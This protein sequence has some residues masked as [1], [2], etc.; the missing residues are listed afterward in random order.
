MRFAIDDLATGYSSPTRIT[1]LPVDILKIDLGFVAGMGIG[2]A[3]AAVVHGNLVMGGTLGPAV[4]A[5]GVETP[6]QVRQLQGFGCQFAQ[7]YHS[8]GPLPKYEL[9]SLLTPRTTT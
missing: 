8:T 7:G 4:F 3:C 5:E 2:P 6:A 1:E 9:A